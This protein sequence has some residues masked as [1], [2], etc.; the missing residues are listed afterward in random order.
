MNRYPVFRNLAGISCAMVFLAALPSEAQLGSV[1][2]DRYRHFSS[3]VEFPVPTGWSVVQT[4]PSSD[5]GDQVYLRDASSPATYA[6][7]WMKRET[8]TKADADALLQLAVRMK[9]D[10]RGGAES[11]YRFRP[12]TVR[13]LRIGGHDAVSA[14]ADFPPTGRVAREVEYFTWIFTERTRVQFDVRG[15]E[16][17]AS[18]TM[19]RLERIIRGATIP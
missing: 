8:N 16:P 4:T 2:H 12:E 18:A 9:V 11:G 17:D 10:Q 7:I 15:T 6:A 5:G 13:H 1:E 14:V 3:S 19:T